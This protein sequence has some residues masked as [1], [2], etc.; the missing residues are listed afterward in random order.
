[1]EDQEKVI[2]AV[3]E[4]ENEEALREAYVIIQ[5][6]NEDIETQKKHS[7]GIIQAY[8]QDVESDAFEVL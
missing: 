3:M 7:D 8:V 4:K 5:S 6:L 2:R 1:M